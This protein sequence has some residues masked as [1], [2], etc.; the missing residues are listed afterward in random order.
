MG[1]PLEIKNITKKSFAKYGT[2]LEHV[3][4]KDGYEAIVTVNS[5]G[6]IWAVRTFGIKAISTLQSHP[7]SRESFEPV[8]G[9][10]VLVVAPL[11]S[12]EKQEA[13]LLDR[14]VLLQA[15]VWHG[16]ISLAESTRV[17]ISENNDVT[18]N[19]FKLGHA[20]RIVAEG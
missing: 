14:P 6:W 9:V 1:R 19:E 16:L 18:T 17:K 10:A 15:G 11:A 3:K 7:T 4:Q 12:P 13:F 8:F 2:V 5:R 20:L